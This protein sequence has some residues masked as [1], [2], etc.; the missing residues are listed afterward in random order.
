[1]KT[2]RKRIAILSSC[3]ALTLFA[4]AC[5]DDD[6]GVPDEPGGDETP[7]ETSDGAGG[8]ATT[9]PGVGVTDTDPGSG[10]ADTGEGGGCVDLN[11]DGDPVVLP[12]DVIIVIDTS[13]SMNTE[14]DE[15][16]SNINVNFSQIIAASGIDYQVFMI[17]EHGNVGT[18]VCIGQPLSMTTNCLDPAP[19]PRPNLFY[20]WNAPGDGAGTDP[21]LVLAAIRG[22]YDNAPLP[23][24]PNPPPL[25]DFFPLLDTNGNYPG[26]LAPLIR[27]ESIKHWIW[28]SDDHPYDE[29]GT[30]HFPNPRGLWGRGDWNSISD[31]ST[32]A[33]EAR[34]FE[35]ELAAIDP[36]KFAPEKNIHHGIIGV[37]VKPTGLPYGPLEPIQLDRCNVSGN[38][39][40]DANNFVQF[41]TR[42]R[43]ERGGL[44]FPVCDTASYDDVFN[45]V[46]TQVVGG[47]AVVC[48]FQLPDPE[49]LD[50][51]VAD[52]LRVVY[53]PGD[54]SSP[55]TFD[56]VA[57]EAAC[58]GDDNK[59]YVVDETIFLCPD[60]CEVV[61]DDFEAS[62]SIEADCIPIVE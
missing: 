7:T 17:A 32:S 62:V 13:G 48:E 30:G 46:A 21:E 34:R 54:G 25:V 33:Q 45:A 29:T 26:G 35:R 18:Q 23:P 41:L 2:T 50:G 8:G 6:F 59:F 43:E 28:I 31:G 58:Q 22:G 61:Q 38:S 20:H 52:S 16:E 9:T 53:T 12:T 49:E 40:P 5:S 24:I 60:A 15:V 39:A 19:T 10:G 57:S 4:Y 3:C 1:M 56:R 55:Q 36:I 11:I 42:L 37:D 44:R 51:F 47:A 14:I 27:E